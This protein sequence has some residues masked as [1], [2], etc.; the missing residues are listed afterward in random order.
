MISKMSLIV[1]GVLSLN[2]IIHA[3]PIQPI[4]EVIPLTKQTSIKSIIDSKSATTSEKK[5]DN[6]ETKRKRNVEAIIP[7]DEFTDDESSEEHDIEIKHKLH[8]KMKETPAQIHD[9]AE[10]PV[11]TDDSKTFTEIKMNQ[12][13]LANLSNQRRRRH[14][15]FND[16]SNQ[17]HKR[18]LS[19]YGLYDT[20]PLYASV[21]ERQQFVRPTRS[22]SPIYWYPSSYE[23]N[24]RSAL[25]SSLYDQPEWSR[26]AVDDIDEDEN[27]FLNDDDEYQTYPIVY[28]SSE[29]PQD[30]NIAVDDDDYDDD[31]DDDLYPLRYNPTYG[32]LKK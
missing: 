16:H 19:A 26:I 10:Q 12:N 23:R 30:Y 27:T 32:Y 4:K 17:R 24:T 13:E 6:A 29:L 2:I 25:I 1:Y 11:A 7:F 8:P 31:D 28:D 14:V 20:D 9:N 22:F 3:L 15:L 21:L 18:A 5:H